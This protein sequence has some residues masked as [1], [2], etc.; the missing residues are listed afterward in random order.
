MHCRIRQTMLLCLIYRFFI[1]LRRIFFV[2]F[3]YTI[4]PHHYQDTIAFQV[5]LRRG[6]P[7]AT[8]RYYA[9]N[10]IFFLMAVYFCIAR[11]NY[12]FVMRFGPLFLALILL[13]LT[14]MQRSC[15]PRV[16]RATVQ[17]YIKLKILP[18]DF[19]SVHTLHIHGQE[20]TI[21][22][23]GKA[24]S[25]HLSQCSFVHGED[26]VSFILGGGVIFELIPNEVLDKDHR[27]DTLAALFTQ[28]DED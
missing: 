1:F 2:N 28:S 14:T 3:C 18:Q 16:L 10:G 9:T 8:L 22:Y 19:F 20:L 15:A 17:R 24:Q 12:S 7:G 26:S 4:A 25:I 13:S 21:S 27:R 11:P 6:K 5:R 23:A